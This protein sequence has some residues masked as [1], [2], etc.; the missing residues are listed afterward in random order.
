MPEKTETYRCEVCKGI[1]EG[2]Y[3]AALEHESIPK[4]SPLQTGL[5]LKD[6]SIT[7]FIHFLLVTCGHFRYP[8]IVREGDVHDYIHF[9]TTLSMYEGRLKKYSSI[10]EHS[11]RRIKTQLKKGKLTIIPDE[12]F[13]IFRQLYTQNKA[14]LFPASQLVRTYQELEEIVASEQVMK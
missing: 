1:F 13:T 8:D 12:E 6:I 5:V 11:S 7:D 3:E 2:T 4:D 14:L 9:V 10:D